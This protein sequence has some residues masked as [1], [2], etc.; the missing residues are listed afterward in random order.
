MFSKAD[1]ELYFNAE[2]SES[3]FF[4]IVG[5]LGV[6]SALAL[7]FFVKPT[8]AKGAA[9]PVF[10]VGLLMVIVGA[11]VF[12]RSDEQRKD[13][14]YKLDMNTEAIILEEIPRMEKVMAN[15]VYY[16]YTEIFLL[17]AGVILF[18]VFRSK[19]NAQWWMGLGLSLAIMA[20]IMLLADG[21]AE[22]RGAQYFKGLKEFSKR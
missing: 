10:L 18:F 2:K 16:R 7:F 6:I 22:R 17:T 21:F 1:V 4:M 3:L 5:I 19:S 15:F 12:S 14:V 9:I 8:W 11:I 13:I 20:G